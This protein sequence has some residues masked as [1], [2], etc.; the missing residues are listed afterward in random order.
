[1]EEL[2][3][4]HCPWG[5]KGSGTT[6]RLHFLVILS[7][8][9]DSTGIVCVA[10]CFDNNLLFTQY[11]FVSVLQSSIILDILGNCRCSVSAKIQMIMVSKVQFLEMNQFTFNM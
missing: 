4:G 6:K 2:G 11:I 7:H 9:T 3:A 1:M 10:C 5:C 8:V